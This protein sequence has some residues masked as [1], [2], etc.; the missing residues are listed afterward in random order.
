LAEDASQGLLIPTD[1]DPADTGDNYYF[2]IRA[3]HSLG[4]L[5]DLMVE[6][7]RASV[8]QIVEA[9]L[10]LVLQWNDVQAPRSS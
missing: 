2:S 6:A 7:K 1:L 5:P 9:L 8:E 4:S 10:R 3:G